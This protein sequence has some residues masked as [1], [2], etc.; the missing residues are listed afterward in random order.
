MTLPTVEGITLIQ[1][2][3]ALL[4]YDGRCY[5]GRLW[6]PVFICKSMCPVVDLEK[7]REGWE[8]IKKTAVIVKKR[9]SQ[10]TGG[11]AIPLFSFLLKK[12]RKK[13]VRVSGGC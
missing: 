4:Y 2:I 8:S 11:S 7:L 1:C 12:N 5:F 10:P 6:L 13:I 3:N 9:F